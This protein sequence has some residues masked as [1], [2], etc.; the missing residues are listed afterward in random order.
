MDESDEYYDVTI[1]NPNGA[2]IA[3]GQDTIRVTILDNDSSPVFTDGATLEVDFAENSTATV[4]TLAATDNDEGDTVGYSLSGTDAGSFN[5]ADGVLTFKEAPD[6]E[7]KSSY[8]ITA[9]ASDGV[10]E[11]NQ[12]ITITITNVGE[13]LSV[14]ES[15]I[16]IDEEEHADLTINLEAPAASDI[17]FDYSATPG[18]AE[19]GSDYSD[20][21]D[22]GTVTILAGS[23]SAGFKIYTGVEDTLDES[24]EYYDVTISNPNGATIATGQ[25]TIR[26]TIL[27]N[28][29][30]P[31]FTDGATLEV[32]F[33]ENSTATV[34]TLAA[35]DQMQAI[36]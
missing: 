12:A 16:T 9:V 5:L 7:T 25:D 21:V 26:V 32:D 10:N 19:R 17:T 28:D 13:V 23:S 8:S 30:S 6:F 31:V 20:S 27:D 24:D 1:S 15:S 14:A 34:T 22:T 3:T 36:Q 33:A 11:V 18:T 2:T 35:T 29:S 4:T